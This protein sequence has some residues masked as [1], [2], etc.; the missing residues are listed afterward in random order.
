MPIDGDIV[1]VFE[2]MNAECIGQ[3][4]AYQDGSINSYGSL[5]CWSK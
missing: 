5:R 1:E 4:L 2:E 3:P